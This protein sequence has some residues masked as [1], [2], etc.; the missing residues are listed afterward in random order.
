VFSRELAAYAKREK[1][2]KLAQMSRVTSSSVKEADV[3]LSKPVPSSETAPLVDSSKSVDIDST[4][5]SFHSSF[6]CLSLLYCN[7]IHL[8]NVNIS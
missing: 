2:R 8:K 1:E 6:S 4:T 3:S 5:R 7:H